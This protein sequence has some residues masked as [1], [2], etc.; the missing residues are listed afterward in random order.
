M[1]DKAV[2]QVAPGRN[3]HLH[4]LW[5]APS[6]KWHTAQTGILFCSEALFSGRLAGMLPNETCISWS[7]L[8]HSSI[9]MFNT[10]SFRDVTSKCKL[11]RLTRVRSLSHDMTSS[12]ELHSSRPSMTTKTSLPGSLVTLHIKRLQCLSY[13]RMLR[14]KLKE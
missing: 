6:K 1:F 13:R 14:S 5:H 8:G 3:P 11:S 12:G 4:S 10:P 7:R 2:I 9:A